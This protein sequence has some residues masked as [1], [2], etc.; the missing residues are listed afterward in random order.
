PCSASCWRPKAENFRI[1]GK[2]WRGM[3][4]LS[5]SDEHPRSTTQAQI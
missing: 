4:T 2:Q 3:A 1:S 5:L